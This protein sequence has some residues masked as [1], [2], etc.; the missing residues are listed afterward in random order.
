[1][2]CAMPDGAQHLVA[3]DARAVPLGLGD[4]LHVDAQLVRARRRTGSL[5]WSAHEAWHSHGSGTAR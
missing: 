1:M 3:V 2:S 4:L 5:K